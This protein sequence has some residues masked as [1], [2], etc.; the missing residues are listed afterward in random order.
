MG[1]KEVEN[2]FKRNLILAASDRLFGKKGYD[3]TTMDDIAKESEFSKPTL[4]V[5]FKSK[6]DIVYA[7]FLRAAKNNVYRYK[8]IEDKKIPFKEKIIEYSQEYL[9]CY[10][11]NPLYIKFFHYWRAYSPSKESLS[12][13]TLQ[14][15][16]QLSQSKVLTHIFEQAKKENVFRNDLDT[17]FAQR[18]FSLI[19]HSIVEFFMSHPSEHE[20][21]IKYMTLSLE[22]YYKV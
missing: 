22:A 6:H 3:G 15:G 13:T 4:Y 17:E 1:R 14:L 9:K 18:H 20:A 2:D 10:L 19:L 11:E 21:F 7:S 8:I 12:D 16:M 5:Y